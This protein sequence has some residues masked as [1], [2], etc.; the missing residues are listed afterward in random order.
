MA[1]NLKDE[2]LVRIYAITAL[3]VIPVALLLMYRTLDIAVINQAKY[4]EMGKD[5]FQERTVTAERGNIY[6]RNNNLLAAS[7]P[8]FSL[9]FDP[10]VASP[11]AYYENIDSLGYLLSK[12]VNSDFTAGAW[13]DSLFAM[14]DSL[15]KPAR[16]LP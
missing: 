8:Y 7:V 4:Q 6:S 5:L 10:Y 15:G 14:R 11:K 13:R 9:H 12:H 2:V 3:I 16:Q 1:L